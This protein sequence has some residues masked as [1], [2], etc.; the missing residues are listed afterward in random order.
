MQE[1]IKDIRDIGDIGKQED[2]REKGIAQS[3]SS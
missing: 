1:D 2:I 3:E